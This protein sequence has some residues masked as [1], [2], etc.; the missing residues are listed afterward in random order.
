M[1]YFSN[2]GFGL[3]CPDKVRIDPLGHVEVLVQIGPRC[4]CQRFA[5]KGV[6]GWAPTKFPQMQP[7]QEFFL[8]LF[9]I[10][11][12]SP[13]PRIGHKRLENTVEQNRIKGLQLQLFDHGFQKN[14]PI[15]EKEFPGVLGKLF[16]QSFSLQKPQEASLRVVFVHQPPSDDVGVFRHRNGTQQVFGHH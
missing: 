14:V 12:V 4:L 10:P 7:S 1:G 8:G 3:H 11:L 6:F 2:G 15:I 5:G 9:R 16:F 13:Q